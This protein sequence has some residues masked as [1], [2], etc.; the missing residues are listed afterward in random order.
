MEAASEIHRP[1]S[2]QCQQS[3]LHI[4][5]FSPSLLNVQFQQSDRTSKP[6]KQPLQM[7][8]ELQWFGINAEC[9]CECFQLRYRQVS[10]SLKILNNFSI[11][12]S[13]SV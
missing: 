12:V 10:I 4:K 3:G 9:C 7:Y 11:S 5:A 6:K 8:T 13:N 1:A 2:L